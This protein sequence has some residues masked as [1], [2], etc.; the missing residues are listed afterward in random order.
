MKYLGVLID[1]NLSWKQ[2]I[3]YISTKIRKGIGIITRL[4]HLVP[5]TTLLNIY[6]SFIEPYISYGLVAWGQA[7]NV[8]LNKVVILQKGVLRLMYFSDYTSHSAPPFACLGI[9]PIQMLYFQLAASLLHDIKNHCAPPNMSQLF[10]RSEQVHSYSTRFSVAGSFYVK[11]ARTNHQLLSFS[12]VSA[13]IWNGIPPEL[14]KL[15]KAPFKCK[16]THLLLGI[17]ETEEMNVD[18]RYIDLSS[19]PAFSLTC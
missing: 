19:F 11:Q 8:H 6:R 16:L 15:R 4:R 3:N 5:L 14:R 12:R 2:H 18:M 9:L 17:L 13:K 7:A 1:E 10:T